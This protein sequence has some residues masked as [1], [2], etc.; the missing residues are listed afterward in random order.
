MKQL[1]AI[2]EN[3]LEWREVSK[4]SLRD[5]SGAILRPLAAGVCDFDRAV[6]QGRY[7]ALPFPIA[8][9][10]EI[11]AEVVEVG[12]EVR[13]I[14]PGMKV[15]L[16]LHISCGACANCVDNRTNSCLS[17][18]PLSNYGLG[19]RGGY[20]GGAMSELVYAPFADAMAVEIPD[21]LTPIDC[22]AI[23]CNL[24]D[25]YRAIAPHMERF[26][27]PR[28]LIVS[29]QAA[30][31]GLYGVAIARALNATEIS[32]MDDDDYFLEAAEALGAQPLAVAPS[33][34]KYEIVVDCSGDR[35][36]LKFAL[37]ATAPSGVCTAV[38]P[39]YETMELPVGAMF[40][41]NVTFIT[42]QPHARAQIEPVLNL[43]KQGALRSTSIPTEILPWRDAEKNFG[44]QKRK[45]ILVR[46]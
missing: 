40:M 41:N 32:F 43:M 14:K 23:G 12:D 33:K 17:R 8:I 16:P 46:D 19:A 39:Y 1:T 34:D 31:M 2:G 27:Q 35:T 5:A 21:G 42:G 9:G 22:A 11:A 44:R 6:V 20:W 25:M 37:A 4:P 24:V 18:P 15:V 13:N 3:T 38:W 10:H 28:I 36:R 29:G 45:Q 30:N 26:P 7:K